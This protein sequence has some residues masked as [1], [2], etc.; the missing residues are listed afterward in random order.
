MYAAMISGMR[1][2]QKAAFDALRA[3]VA[4]MDDGPGKRCVG[5]ARHGG[6]TSSSACSSRWCWRWAG[7]VVGFGEGR[8]RHGEGPVAAGGRHPQVDRHLVLYG[9]IDDMEAFKQYNA[10]I[11]AAARNLVP[12][13]KKI[14]KDWIER[15]EKSSIDEGT[16][17]IGELTGQILALIASFGFAASKAGQVP[18]LALAADIPIMTARGELVLSKWPWWSTSRRPWRRRGLVGTAGPCA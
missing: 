5:G 15:F 18:K 2:A 14:V 17:M 7:I 16:L 13:L 4:A 8:G 1:S 3:S 9:F 11:V 6:S 12:G 10:E